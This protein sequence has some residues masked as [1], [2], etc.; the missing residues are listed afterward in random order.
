MDSSTVKGLAISLFS[1]FCA[2][3][4]PS[5]AIITCAIFFWACNF[6]VGLRV[7]KYLGE[8]LSGKKAFRSVELILVV[9]NILA[10]IAIFG[11]FTGIPIAQIIFA[12]KTV[13]VIFCY[14]M[15]LNI[16]KNLIRRFP[17]EK[18]F[19]VID[20]WLQVEIVTRI[21][22]LKNKIKDEDTIPTN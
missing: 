2:I 3:L 13:G 15:A 1:F 19:R 16:N 5:M 18:F 10:S 7:S 4:D 20:Y 11:Y 6:L 9:T 14:Y 22:F 8:E 17:E 21:P 12:G